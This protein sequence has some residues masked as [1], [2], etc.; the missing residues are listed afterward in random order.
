LKVLFA[1]HGYKPAWR[2]GGPVVSVSSL[3]EALTAKGHEVTVFTTN[4]NLDQD[5]DVPT[6][7]EVDVDGVAVRYFRHEEPLKRLFPRVTYLS[8]SL[9]ILYTPDMAA[10]LERQ[11][12][13]FDVVHTHLP[14]VYPTFAAARAA[15]RFGRPLF[16]HQRGVFDPERLKFRA[17]KK[18]LYLSLI[19]KPILR[20]A[21][22]LIGLTE[23]ERESYAALGVKTPCRVIPNGIHL[24]EP[25]SPDRQQ[26]LL[27]AMDITPRNRVVLFLGRLHPIK[28]A[29]RLLRAFERIAARFPDALLVLAGPD[30]FGIERAFQ[31]RAAAAGLSGRV[32]FPGMI[33]GEVKSA[34]LHRAD[35]F[36]LPSDG[37]GFSM[38]ILEA[39]A[40]A[41]PVLISPGCHFPEVERRG[42]GRIAP[43]DPDA[44]V[45]A[46]EDLLANP[47]RLPR[48]G[49]AGR[50]LVAECYTWESVAA[51][52][53][54]AYEE[55]ID[56]HGRYAK[57]AR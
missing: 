5:L 22:T 31:E 39:L 15:F 4:S 54:E 45:G 55:G 21:T 27:A 51:A 50:A 40:H 20:R 12:R 28:G 34:L 42:A 25:M 6:D 19:E 49:A 8:K 10:E 26:P 24:P 7:R 37:E 36:C 17:L 2:I 44:L 11:A 57:A 46:L 23:A 9:G 18:S 48:M 47:E 38:A 29:D 41:T 13:G 16:Y 56:R 30:E 35:L 33:Q 14:F 53:I 1:V 52:T 32:R 43:L 3:A